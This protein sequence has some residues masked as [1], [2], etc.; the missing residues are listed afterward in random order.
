MGVKARR[1]D[2][3]YGRLYEGAR[4]SACSLLY[5]RETK[6]RKGDGEYVTCHMYDAGRVML[7]EAMDFTQNT[8][9][10]HKRSGGSEVAVTS[11]PHT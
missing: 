4:A 5:R 7:R 9:M 2:G 10:R 6:A 11:G 8:A 1:G 3:E